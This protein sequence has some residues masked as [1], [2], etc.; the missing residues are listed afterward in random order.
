MHT[1]S[2][3][4]P[5]EAYLSLLEVTR[6]RS[7]SMSDVQAENKKES[8]TFPPNMTTSTILEVLEETFDNPEDSRSLQ[9]PTSSSTKNNVINK[10]NNKQLT[11]P[12]SGRA[13]AL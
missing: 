2:L 8:L 6:N 10:M 4:G 5:T 7:H 1:Y 9:T 12:F 3:R 11:C 13:H